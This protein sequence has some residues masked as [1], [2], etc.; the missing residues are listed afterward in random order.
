MR[1]ETDSLS[2]ASSARD[3]D[4]FELL[5]DRHV[6]AV[7]AFCA[8]RLPDEQ[9]SDAVAETFLVL[10]RRIDEAPRGDAEL[11]WLYRVAYRVVGH[12]WRGA[13]R[14]RRLHARLESQPSTGMQGPDDIVIDGDES[15][16]VLAAAAQLK[17]TD[18]EVLR[19]SLWEGLGTADIAVVL[20]IAPN[21][22]HQRLFRAKQRLVREYDRTDHRRSGDSHQEGGTR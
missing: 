13:R 14:R 18:A 20:Q 2:A 16:R 12:A 3:A 9:V 17:P 10:W 15:Q 7:T 21:A 4:R 5:Y 19:L 8:R 11:P 22:V 6:R 1:Q